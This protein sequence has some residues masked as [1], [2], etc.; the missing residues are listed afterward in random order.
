MYIYIMEYV[1]NN[2]IYIFEKRVI[3]S[4]NVCRELER[5]RKRECKREI[6]RGVT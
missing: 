6:T 4:K 5:E 1:N 3:Q 2:L